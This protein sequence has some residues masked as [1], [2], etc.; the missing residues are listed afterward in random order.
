MSPDIGDM[1]IDSDYW[2][3]I[4]DSVQHSVDSDFIYH[5]DNIIDINNREGRVFM[6]LVII[7]ST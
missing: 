5:F 2:S 3:I 4:I 6:L 7:A 1:D